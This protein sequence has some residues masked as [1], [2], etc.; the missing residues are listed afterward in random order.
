MCVRHVLRCCRRTPACRVLISN[1]T[2]SLQTAWWRSSR[3]WPTMPHWWSSRSTTR[4]EIQNYNCARSADLM[5]FNVFWGVYLV[6]VTC[7]KDRKS[8]LFIFFSNYTFILCSQS[9]FT[10]LVRKHGSFSFWMSCFSSSLRYRGRS[11]EIRSRWRSPPCWRTTPASSSSAIISPSR[12]LAP[13]PPWPSHETTT[14]VRND[15]PFLIH[16]HVEFWCKTRVNIYLIW[17]NFSLQF[18]SRD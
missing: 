8:L 17:F 9:Y 6:L 16:V 3:L 15:L 10:H 11:W 2:S 14:W 5:Y 13:E 7:I 12:V 1:P 18:A 4:S